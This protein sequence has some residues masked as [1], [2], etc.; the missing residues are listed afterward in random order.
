MKLRIVLL[1]LLM[2]VAAVAVW[3]GVRSAGQTATIARLESELWAARV[4]PVPSSAAPE[5]QLRRCGLPQTL[6]ATWTG[7]E[8]SNSVVRI[9]VSA[10]SRVSSA[11]SYS[12]QRV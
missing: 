1:A 4:V 11:L 9:A 6:A 8:N 10:W 7:G 12:F 3:L 2:V 5:Q